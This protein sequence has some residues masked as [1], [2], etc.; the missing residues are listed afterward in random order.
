MNIG[1]N[2]K[3]APQAFLRRAKKIWNSDKAYRGDFEV[4][5]VKFRKII[6]SNDKEALKAICSTKSA[7]SFIDGSYESFV[8]DRMKKEVAQTSAMDVQYD[9]EGR[10]QFGFLEENSLHAFEF[11]KADGEWTIFRITLGG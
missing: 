10:K 9:G 11:K 5:W 6:A 1:E 2:M 8:D 7:K 4:F 3:N